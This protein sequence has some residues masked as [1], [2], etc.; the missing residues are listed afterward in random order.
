MESLTSKNAAVRSRERIMSK[1]FSALCTLLLIIVFTPSKTHADPVFI[2]SGS[3]TVTGLEGPRYSLFGNNFSANGGG[4]RG[5]V[6]L[7]TG[8]FIS[9]PGS[10]INVNA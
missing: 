7:Q 6:A 1:L 3:L 9:S 8:F 5:A 2:T 10:V 4:D